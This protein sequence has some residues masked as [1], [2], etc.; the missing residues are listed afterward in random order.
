[1]KQ[2]QFSEALYQGLTAS[3]CV[4]VV[5][6]N[7]LS[8]KMVPLP[9]LGLV[10]PAG[11]ITYPL[12]FM[13]SDLVTELYGAKKAK[14]MVYVALAMS[15]LSLALIQLGVMLPSNDM[16]AELAFSTV[17]GLSSL[18][19]VASLASY[20]AS[21]LIAIKLYA[22]IKQW[23]GPQMLWLRNNGATG[24]A[25]MADTIMVDLIVLWWGLGMPIGDVLPIMLFSYLY[26]AGFSV[27]GTPFFYL[28][29]FL[30]KTRIIKEPVGVTQ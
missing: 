14:L 29:V 9:L 5:V 16:A 21:Q 8:A 6:S 30:A 18:R 17:M 23:S 13:L 24:I 10:V 27:A 25:Q 28:F 26:K 3:F 12:T 4:I 15:L 2:T 22:A 11:L 19:I 7:I 20:F 1:M